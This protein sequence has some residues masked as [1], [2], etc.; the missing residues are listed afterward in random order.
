MTLILTDSEYDELSDVDQEALER[1][2]RICLTHKDRADQLQ[3]ERKLASE[4]D[5]WDTATFAAYSCQV[6]ALRLLPWQTPPCWVDDIEGI[7]AG[8]DDGEMGCYA[9]AR[10]LK[11]LLAAG[12]SRYEP[13]P[14]GA[15]KRAKA[16]A[17]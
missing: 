4:D 7:L 16:P 8:G 9:A 2:I 10:L 12:L 6:D 14:I 11:R 3:M 15:L 5:W 17:P 1:A 13:D